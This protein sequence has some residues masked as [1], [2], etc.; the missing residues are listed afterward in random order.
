MMKPKTSFLKQVLALA[1]L[2]CGLSSPASAQTPCPMPASVTAT[3]PRC[4]SVVFNWPAVTGVTDYLYAVN[5]NPTYTG[6]ASITTSTSGR[7]GGLWPN[8]TYYV[9]VRSSC[10]TTNSNWV[11]TSFTTPTCGSG[12]CLAPNTVTVGTITNNSISYTWNTFPGA[13]GYEYVVDQNTTNPTGSGTFTT[14]STFTATGLTSGN[15]YWLH[16]RTKCGPNSFSPWSNFTQNRTTGA[17]PNCATP[18]P[19]TSSFLRCDSIVFNWPAVSGHTGYLY[20]FAPVS[21]VPPSIS[22]GLTN[23]VSRRNLNASTLYYAS[24]VANC[25]MGRSDTRIDSFLTPACTGGTN[26]LAP[27][28]ATITSV[29]ATTMSASWSAIQ[30]AV[31]YEVML[32]RTATSP[33]TAGNARTTTNASATGLTPNTTYYFHVR[34]Q[35]AT[36]RFSPWR[37]AIAFNTPAPASVSSTVDPAESALSVYPNP[38][39]Q[40]VTV[41]LKQQ[42]G[43]NAQLEVL[44]IDGKVLKRIAAGTKNVIATQE[45]PSGLYLIRFTDETITEMTRFVKQ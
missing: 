18:G 4:D 2:S 24:V 20:T 5:Q 26:C 23:S 6:P 9:H 3:T 40:E 25:G 8:T 27:A 22:I 29:T 10:A 33:T 34:T 37:T 39:Y 28:S 12:V 32:T 31:G 1:L 21:N 44:S 43:R 11:R 15:L 19:I 41:E 30:G 17:D 14:G 38:A 35:C 7:V 42:P 16:V 13:Q 36:N 45:L